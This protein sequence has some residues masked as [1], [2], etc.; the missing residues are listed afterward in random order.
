MNQTLNENKKELKKVRSNIS[1]QFLDADVYIE[2]SM[3]PTKN[4]ATQSKQINMNIVEKSDGSPV[5]SPRGL[6]SGVL[7]KIRSTRTDNFK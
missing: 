3:M 2:S 1:A 4:P 6:K 5:Q 7:P